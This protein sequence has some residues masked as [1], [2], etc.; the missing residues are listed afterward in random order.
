MHFIVITKLDGIIVTVAK[1]L[2]LLKVWIH[3]RH[4]N[5]SQLAVKVTVNSPGEVYLDNFGKIFISLF[6]KPVVND[7][8]CF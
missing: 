2:K 4:L 7:S 8:C 5:F 1:K 3:F 6:K